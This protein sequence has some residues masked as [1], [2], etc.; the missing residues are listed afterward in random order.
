[1]LVKVYKGRGGPRQQFQSACG[2]APSDAFLAGAIQS[3]AR[4]GRFRVETGG[5]S[6]SSGKTNSPSKNYKM[7][8]QHVSKM[9]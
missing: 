6:T 5:L 7:C 9:F 1:M 3:A 4:S 8:E 2:D